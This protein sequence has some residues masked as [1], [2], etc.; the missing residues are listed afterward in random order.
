MSYC[1][2]CS[3]MSNKCTCSIDLTEPRLESELTVA[4]NIMASENPHV[5]SSN[6]NIR[7]LSPDNSVSLLKEIENVEDYKTPKPINIIDETLYI[8]KLERKS[9]KPEELCIREEYLN[10]VSLELFPEEELIPDANFE[11]YIIHVNECDTCREFVCICDTLIQCPMPGCN[12]KYNFNNSHP[13]YEMCFDCEMK[14]R[15]Q[16][17]I[18]ELLYPDDIPMEL[19]YNSDRDSF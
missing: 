1:E 7:I 16:E 11:D 6:K 9:N 10:E 5:E 17:L 3:N 12:N 2:F 8:P 19:R 15:K 14:E 13:S 4:D 18:D